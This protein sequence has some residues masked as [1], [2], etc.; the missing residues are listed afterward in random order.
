MRKRSLFLFICCVFLFVSAYVIKPSEALACSCAEPPSVE[1]NLQRKTA[2]FTGKVIRIEQ[3]KPEEDGSIS[4]AV[5]VKITL[6]VAKVWKGELGKETDVYTAKDGASCGYGD[7]AL[8]QEFIV[9]AYGKPD[10]LETGVCEGNKPV[11]KAEKEI[12]ALGEG[13]APSSH[14]KPT[15][16]SDTG[17]TNESL[18]IRFIVIALIITVVMCITVLL[19]VRIK[20]RGKR[21]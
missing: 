14:I 19:Y 16:H 12:T 21:Q 9:F 20:R 18:P 1:E 8:D 15:N 2:V 6:E 11:S 3:P 10:R 4:S 13:Y 5:P 17:S 7:F